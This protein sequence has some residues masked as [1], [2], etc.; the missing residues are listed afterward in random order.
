M[1]RSAP[2]SFLLP[3]PR[4]PFHSSV[5]KFTPNGKYVLASTLDGRIRLWSPEDNLKVK[6]YSGHSNTQF[7]VAASMLTCPRTRHTQVVSGGEDGNICVWDLQSCRMTKVLRGHSGEFCSDVLLSS[8][9]G[10]ADSLMTGFF[11]FR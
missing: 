6:E 8:P 4:P 7:C 3:W 5:T 11:A 9:V 10:R 1:V 2:N